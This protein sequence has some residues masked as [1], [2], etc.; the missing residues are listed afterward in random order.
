[1]S[2]IKSLDY[3][4]YKKN[5]KDVLKILSSKKSKKAPTPIICMVQ[6]KFQI[7][8]KKIAQLYYL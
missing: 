7:K 4:I 3:K 6:N 2:G 5:E 8:N 1:M